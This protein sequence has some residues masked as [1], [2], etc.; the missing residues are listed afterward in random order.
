MCNGDHQR[1]RDQGGSEACP[2]TRDLRF[3]KFC[4]L[5]VGPAIS[6]VRGQRFSLQ[7]D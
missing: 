5:R 1:H 2:L 6:A 4:C 3:A 7:R